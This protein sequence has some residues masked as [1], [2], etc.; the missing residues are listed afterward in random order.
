MRWWSTTPAIS[1]VCWGV[2][3]VL[4]TPN[5]RGRAAPSCSRRAPAGR[6]SAKCALAPR[7]RWRNGGRHDLTY[8]I[9]HLGDGRDWLSSHVDLPTGR[10]EYINPFRLGA[11]A[12]HRRNYYSAAVISHIVDFAETVRGE[13]ESEYTDEDALMAM[14]MEVATRESALQ[15]GRRLTLPLEG[16]L[17]S[18]AAIRAEEKKLYGVDP[19]DIEGMLQISY[20]RP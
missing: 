15:E 9:V 19:L 17:E 20:P 6:A 12:Y 11:N 16:D 3:R 14:M 10:I 8:P 13:R 4:V 7:K 5:W 18:E 2:I 1:R